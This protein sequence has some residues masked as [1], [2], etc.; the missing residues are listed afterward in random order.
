VVALAPEIAVH[1]HWLGYALAAQT[2]Y[3]EAVEAYKKVLSLDPQ[4]P[5]GLP[6]IAYI[7]LAAGRAAD[8]VPY[9]QQIRELVQQKR[10]PDY[11]PSVCFYLALA[12]RESGEQEKAKN[13]S[14][15]GIEFL[16]KEVGET[17]EA[18]WVPLLM[19]KLDM[20]CG[21]FER[22]EDYIKQAK[23]LGLNDQGAYIY[24]AEVYALAGKSREA[25]DT[26]KQVLELGHRDPYF[27]QIFP[28]FHSLQ[29]NPEFQA[30]FR[31]E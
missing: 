7:L 21:R 3:D 12:L 16:L 23:S 11:Y 1:H 31:S 25:I 15:E 5:W 28:A 26:L 8:A 20:A 27:L 4:H 30:L 19:A 29:A 13:I 14:N 6:N 10:L 18:A 24:L 2:R 9:F 17:W 22:A